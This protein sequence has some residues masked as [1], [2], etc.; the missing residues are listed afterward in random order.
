MSSKQHPKVVTIVG[1]DQKRHVFLVK[2]G[3]DLRWDRNVQSIFRCI[4]R[5]FASTP[6]NPEKKLSLR[7]FDVVPLSLECGLLQWYLSLLGYPSR[8]G[9]D[10]RKLSTLILLLWH[11]FPPCA[12]FCY[13]PLVK[14]AGCPTRYLYERFLARQLLETS[15]RLQT[16]PRETHHSR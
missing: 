12:L 10:G 15:R 5:A 3:E 13:P 6:V 8:K 11:G 14:R 4:N 9:Q 2:G 7:T 16:Y 1:D